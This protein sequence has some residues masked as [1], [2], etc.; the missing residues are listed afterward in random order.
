V[1]L[2]GASLPV[3]DRWHSRS[4]AAVVQGIHASAHSCQRNFPGVRLLSV[5]GRLPPAEQHMGT[6]FIPHLSVLPPRHCALHKTAMSL[7]WLSLVV[8]RSLQI[9]LS[10]LNSTQKAAAS[11]QQAP[12]ALIPTR[13]FSQSKTESHTPE[14]PIPEYVCVLYQ[15]IDPYWTLLPPFIAV[16]YASH[17]AAHPLGLRFAAAFSL[18]LFWSQRLTRSYF[19]R[20]IPLSTPS[21][22][23]RF[24]LV[25]PSLL[26]SDVAGR[27][28]QVH[29]YRKLFSSFW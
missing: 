9:S 7:V 26:C 19:R 14:C 13:Y 16:A 25:T 17:P 6:S 15:L 1:V 28:F 12:Q 21:L 20:C 3:H 27:L 23:P 2:V 4:P 11:L 18:L 22:M 29:I 8:A 10:Q 24:S 5:L